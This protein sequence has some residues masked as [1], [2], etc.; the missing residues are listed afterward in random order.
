MTII[1]DRIANEASTTEAAP[2]EAPRMQTGAPGKVRVW[3]PL[4]RLFHWS[5]VAVFA[6]A[7]L[8]A[9]ETL[10]RPRDRG[11]MWSRDSSRCASSEGWLVAATRASSSS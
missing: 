2:H 3:D 9:E 6:V 7:W 4:L 10:L 5:L 8:S 11:G 1:R